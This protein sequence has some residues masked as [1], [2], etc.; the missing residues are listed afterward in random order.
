MRSQACNCLHHKII[1]NIHESHL[2]LSWQGRGRWVTQPKSVPCPVRG[3][4]EGSAPCDTPVTPL[5]SPSAGA[6]PPLPQQESCRGDGSREFPSHRLRNC[7]N[8]PS[9]EGSEQRFSASLTSQSSGFTCSY[10]GKEQTCTPDH[11]LVMIY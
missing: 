1:Q 8:S 4:D 7:T 9:R 3:V 11:V 6:P 2:G 10:R 5:L